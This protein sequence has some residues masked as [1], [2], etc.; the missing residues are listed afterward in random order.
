M[1]TANHDIL[2]LCEIL[3][4]MKYEGDI[5]FQW[6][7]LGQSDPQPQFHILTLTAV[8]VHPLVFFMGADLVLLI[9]NGDK[10]Y[11]SINMQKLT[12]RGP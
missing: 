2:L 5:L 6:L 3:P 11:V 1:Y 12:R 10:P 7:L 9:P 8:Q 4:I